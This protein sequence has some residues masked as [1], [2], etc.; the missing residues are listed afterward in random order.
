MY[1]ISISVD[2]LTKGKI[3]KAKNGTDIF[4]NLADNEVGIS[5]K[6]EN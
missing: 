5:N 3:W 6:Y 2:I 4:R 1:D